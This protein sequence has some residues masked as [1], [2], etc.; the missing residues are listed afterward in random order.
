MK[1][2]FLVMDV[3]GTIFKATFKLHGVDYKSTLWQPIAREL[4]DAA[5]DEEN[6]M[7]QKYEK[8]EYASYLDWVKATIDM[9]KRYSLKKK[10]FDNLIDS[11]EYNTGVEEFFENLNRNEWI[12]VLISGGFQNLIRRAENEL[13][14]E[15]GFGACEYYF[16]DY[17]YLVSHNIQPCDF[18]GKIKF[19]DTLLSD[20]KMN[21]K[22]DWVFV[23]DGK[24]DIPIA[25]AAPKAFG[26]NPHDD[27]KKVDGLIE[28]HSF[29]DLL[30]YLNE[31]AHGSSSN[32]ASGEVSHEKKMPQAKDDISKLHKRI[33]DLKK[34]NRDLKQKINDK[35]FKDQKRENIKKSEIEVRDIDYK[36]TPKKELSELTKGLKIVFI[37]L[38]EHYESFHRLSARNDIKVIPAGNNNFDQNIISNADFLFIYKNCISHSDIYHAFSGSIPAYCFL[39]EPTNQEVLENAMANVLYRFLYE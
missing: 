12:P 20:F 31:I 27:L 29:M 14:I 23:G 2:R 15:Y 24:N 3:E 38:N 21:K 25:K 19:L 5:M 1:K 26:I 13:D 34:Q 16:D 30:P 35:A 36:I 22:T 28:I 17:G 10:V 6:E 11:A 37:G 9:H 33:A 39:D 7:A 32:I 8:G 4:G 18:E